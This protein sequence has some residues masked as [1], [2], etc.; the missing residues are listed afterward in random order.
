MSV[1]EDNST[2]VMETC[3]LQHCKENPDGAQVVIVFKSGGTV[4]GVCRVNR[5][6]ECDATLFEIMGPGQL[7]PQAPAMMLSH[8]FTAAQ[9]ERVIIPRDLPKPEI[10]TPKGSGGI[11]IPG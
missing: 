6:S 11:V 8:Y 10:Y 3:L 2:S 4:L 9:V 5:P 1:T 7:G